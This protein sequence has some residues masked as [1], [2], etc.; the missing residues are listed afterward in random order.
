MH[1]LRRIHS[2]ITSIVWAPLITLRTTITF[3]IRW[4]WK[5]IPSVNWHPMI[6]AR[7]PF[8]IETLRN[9]SILKRPKFK[10]CYRISKSMNNSKHLV[11]R[12]TQKSWSQTSLRWT[13]RDKSRRCKL[14]ISPTT[15]N[16]KTTNFKEEL[17]LRRFS[18][19][20]FV[21]L[22]VWT[23]RMTVSQ[24][25]WEPFQR[26][27]TN[28]LTLKTEDI[29]WRDSPKL[30][31]SRR[32]K[33]PL[34]FWRRSRTKR[35]LMMTITTNILNIHKNRISSILSNNMTTILLRRLQIL[36]NHEFLSP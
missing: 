3:A 29:I 36:R 5:I 14:P 34:T 21:D 16:M 18:P 2:Q 8:N 12:R 23:N 19:I 26:S 24:W 6:T 9:K 13:V 28:H 32:T 30:W 20:K 31:R 4:I 25:C 35:S 7:I 22:L 33:D 17:I 1:V 27:T 11:V 10:T 15:S